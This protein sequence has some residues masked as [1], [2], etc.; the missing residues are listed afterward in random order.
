MEVARVLHS[1]SVDE[2]VPRCTKS[3]SVTIN[4][5]VLLQ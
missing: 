4:Q 5:V 1:G 2:N 3:F